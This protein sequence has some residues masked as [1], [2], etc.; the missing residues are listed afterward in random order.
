MPPGLQRESLLAPT[1]TTRSLAT[2][3]PRALQ[4]RAT[5]PATRCRTPPSFPLVR[6]RR[7][8]RTGAV[9]APTTH[10]HHAG[11]GPHHHHS[12]G[13]GAATGAAAGIEATVDYIHSLGLGMGLYTARGQHT[14][15]GYAA[16]CGYEAVDA[17]Q[18]AAWNI[19]YLKVSSGHPESRVHRYGGLFRHAAKQREPP[20]RRAWCRTTTAVRAVTT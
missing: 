11:G 3:H 14:C 9:Q 18:Y 13:L 2:Q 19:D 8:M 1:T 17:A 12:P 16:S 20:P 7:L 5:P 4:P 15:A 10:H 6:L